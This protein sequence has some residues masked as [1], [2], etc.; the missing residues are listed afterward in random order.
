MINPMIVDGQVAGGVAQGIGAALLEEITYG[1]TASCAAAAS[2]TI[3]SR[4]PPK[5]RPSRS[6][7]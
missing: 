2:W 1:P 7:T 3:S 5:C 4:P 6:G